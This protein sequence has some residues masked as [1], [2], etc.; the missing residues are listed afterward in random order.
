LEGYSVNQAEDQFPRQSSRSRKTVRNIS[1][2]V[3]ILVVAF[4]VLLATRKPVN[5]QTVASPLLNKPA[6][7]ISGTSLQGR[8]ISLAD[9]SGKFVLVNFFASW[10][11]PCQSEEQNLVRFAAQHRNVKVLG[12][13]YDDA[14]SSARQ[15]LSSFGANYQAVTDPQGQIALSYGVTNP[16]QTYLISPQGTILTEILGPVNLNSLNQLI[17]IAKSKG[18]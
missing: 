16:P 11:T 6:P 2:I 12:V 4:S 3:G 10:C 5:M 9:Y 7:E 1:I 14:N 8:Q 18:Y 13:P 17:A 15:F